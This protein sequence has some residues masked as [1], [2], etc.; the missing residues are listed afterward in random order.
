M[1]VPGLIVVDIPSVGRNMLNHMSLA[2]TIFIIIQVGI[3]LNISVFH[4][5][6]VNALV[7]HIH[8]SISVTFY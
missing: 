1:I 6:G 3:F 4:V 2:V 7:V 5:A 8:F